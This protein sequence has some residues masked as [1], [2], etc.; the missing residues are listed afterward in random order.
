MKTLGHYS[1]IREALDAFS[2]SPRE[3][4]LAEAAVSELSIRRNAE[5]WEEGSAKWK[6]PNGGGGNVTSQWK[7][8]FRQ[9]IPDITRKMDISSTQLGPVFRVKHPAP[10][11]NDVVRINTK[12]ARKI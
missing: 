4:L 12:Q 6:D 10:W 9:P 8:Y 7:K 11:M 5:S 1:G 3:N 2:T